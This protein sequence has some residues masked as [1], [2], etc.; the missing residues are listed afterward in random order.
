M[1]HDHRRVVADEPLLVD[2]PPDQVDVLAEAQRR[3][4]PV[5]ERGAANEQARAGYVG[6]RGAWADQSTEATHV[7]RTE[8]AFV[9]ITDR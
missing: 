2:E 9:V 6:C 3:V 8:S 4:E 1:G 5:G 7:E